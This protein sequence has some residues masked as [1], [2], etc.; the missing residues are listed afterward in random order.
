MAQIKFR[1]DITTAAFPLLYDWAGRTVL[2]PTTPEGA[3]PVTTPQVLYA[4]DVLP[5]IQGYK[6]VSYKDLVP[7]ASP[8]NT[9]FVQEYT[10]SDPAQN[11]ALIGITKDSKIYILTNALPTWVDV[12]PIGWAGGDAVSVGNANGTYYLYLA[13]KGCY[14]VGI[15]TPGLTLTTLIGITAANIL[16]IFSAVNYLLLWD[17][18]G[19]IYWGGTTT[20]TT[21]DFTF[22]LIT[23]A[24][25]A[26]PYDIMGRIVTVV[27][28][29]NGYVIYTNNNII[30]ASF[31]NN[32][33]FPWI[34]RNAN[35]GSGIAD[36]Y[37]VS[38]SHDLAFHVANTFA[39]ILQVTPQGCE[40]IVP[41]VTDFLA[42]RVYE[43]YDSVNNVIVKQAL[44]ANVVTRI[45]VLGARYIV[46]SYGITTLTDVIVYDSAL[47]R[48]GRLSIPHTCC[49]EIETSMEGV[50]Q[51][52]NQA[53]EIGAT[54][55]AASPQTYGS[56]TVSLGNPPLVG[57]IFGFLQASGT[58]RLAY[59]DYSSVADS[60][61]LMLGKFQARR[62]YL[63]ELEEIA[64]E[65]IPTGTNFT[66]LDLA[67]INGKDLL[68]AISPIVVLSGA[69]IQLYKCRVVSKN[70]TLVFKGSFNLTTVD[71]TATLGSRR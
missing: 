43:S 24:G 44:T 25:S 67:S 8:V 16:G 54:Y 23:G 53:S 14:A 4:Q 34:W 51:P 27:S 57:R 9:N 7:A 70:H 13:N 29:N 58:V 22:S 1:A 71:I 45:N 28:L 17:A 61:V 6:S 62:D 49:F 33:Q 38:Y 52:Y 48:W 20:A 50:I 31:S 56:T 11:K 60:G 69:G 35:N 2:Q 65:T 18:A 40:V 64:V 47:K 42:A 68:P 37:Q 15:T 19:V 12:T 26:T 59:L 32:T 39:G 36:K 5:T 21:L 41:E 3:P 46:L 55:A 30:L 66:L 10:V 63:L